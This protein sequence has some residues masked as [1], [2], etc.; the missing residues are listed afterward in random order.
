MVPLE[1]LVEKISKGS[2]LKKDDIEKLIEEKR[3]ELSGLVSREGAAYIIGRELGINLI[4]EGRQEFKIKNL[5]PDLNFID[6]A[7]KVVSISSVRNF[8]KNGKK[9]SVQNVLLGDETGRVYLVLWGDDIQKFSEIKEGDSIK[10]MQAYSKNSKNGSVEISLGKRGQAEKIDK[11]IDVVEYDSQ[12][13]KN[14][15]EKSNRFEIKNLKENQWG[16]IRGC[17][18][19]VFRRS[20]IYTACSSCGSSLDKEGKCKSHGAENDP[21]KVAMLSGIIDDGTGTIRVILFRE[22][23][24]KIYCLKASEINLEDLD[25]F[26]SGLDVLGKEFIIGGKVKKNNFSGDLEMVANKVGE[27]DAKKECELLVKEIGK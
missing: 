2:G 12:A 13:D 7:A 11:K 16:E 17:F 14:I 4:K 21:Q 6:L 10:V 18:V 3:T 5:L 20:P 1:E 24:E 19:Q 25:G 22:M 15:E 26:Y 23:A 27:V 8:E 9:G